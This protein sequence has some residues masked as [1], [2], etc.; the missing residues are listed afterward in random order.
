MQNNF[1]TKFNA[2]FLL[3]QHIHVIEICDIDIFTKNN[4]PDEKYNSYTLS[5]I[6]IIYPH[7]IK[8]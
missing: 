1:F 8:E 2:L 6:L 3:I 5:F 7:Y 4:F